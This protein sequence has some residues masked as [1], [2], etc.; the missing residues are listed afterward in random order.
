MKLSSCLKP[1]MC[2]SNIY[3]KYAAVSQLTINDFP[4]LGFIFQSLREFAVRDSVQPRNT[5][6]QQIAC[7]VYL[8]SADI[9]CWES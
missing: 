5:V 4:P 8:L 1:R 7:R 9:A 2:V 6:R 3:P